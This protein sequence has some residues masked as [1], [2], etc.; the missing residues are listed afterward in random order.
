MGK[1]VIGFPI[2]CKACSLGELVAL[3]TA[4]EVAYLHSSYGKRNVRVI[5]LL[6]F[7]ALILRLKRYLKCI[8]LVYF[9]F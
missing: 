1:G 8:K 9:Y 4:A 3:C 7:T 5:K 6:A 2:G